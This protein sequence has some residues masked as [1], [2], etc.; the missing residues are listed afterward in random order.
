[1]QF[2]TCVFCRKQFGLTI[3]LVTV[4]RV[5]HLLGRQSCRLCVS[6]SDVNDFSVTTAELLQCICQYLCQTL[7]VIIE[8][9]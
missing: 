9:D 3:R 7:N 8:G 5:D 6:L 2:V 1:M 4:L